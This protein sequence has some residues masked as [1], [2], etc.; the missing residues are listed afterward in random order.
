MN[1][2]T[3]AGNVTKDSELRAAGQDNVLQFAVADNQ[4]KDKQPIFWNCDLWG[5]RGESLQQYIVK[6]QAVTVSGVVTQ[7]EYTD[8]DGNQKRA[9]SIKVQEIALQGGKT[10]R[11]EAPR[12]APVR[13]APAKTSGS[14]FD[15]MADDIPF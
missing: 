3:V 15:D 7:R 14:G 8:K 6:G 5:K 10:E 1:I 2:I 9:M 4:G 13:T 11:S 12:Q